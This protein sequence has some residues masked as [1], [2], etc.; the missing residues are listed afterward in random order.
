[1]SRQARHSE[2]CHVR[3]SLDVPKVRI[4][5][6]LICNS[7]MRQDYCS[8]RSNIMSIQLTDFLLAEEESW[9]AILAKVARFQTL[10]PNR[11]IM[12]VKVEHFRANSDNQELVC[13]KSA[14]LIVLRTYRSSRDPK[15][16]T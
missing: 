14:S 10:N 3:L 15:T 7:A 9:R 5:T 16:H 6:R 13:F 11:S 8:S 2:V 1:M 12:C 4:L